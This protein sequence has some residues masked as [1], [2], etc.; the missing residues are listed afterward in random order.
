MWTLT[1]QT[2]D[3]YCK[4]LWTH[5]HLILDPR[6]IRRIP[7]ALHLSGKF[8]PM[9]CLLRHFAQ[10]WLALGGY[11]SFALTDTAHV[12]LENITWGP[13]NQMGI[14][15]RSVLH[16]SLFFYSRVKISIWASPDVPMIGLVFSKIQKKSFELFE[17][18]LCLFWIFCR[19][20]LSFVGS[21]FVVPSFVIFVQR[22]I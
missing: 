14:S 16:L 10:P 6:F 20:H 3:R 12:P 21:S 19:P 18:F 4:P 13:F 9:S 11:G 1:A 7:I 15:F 22:K 5:L 8:V 17:A 2:L